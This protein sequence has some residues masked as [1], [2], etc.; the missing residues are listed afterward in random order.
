MKSLLTQEELFNKISFTHI[1]IDSCIWLE[2]YAYTESFEP[3]IKYLQ[4]VQCKILTLPIIKFEVLRSQNLENYQ[5]LDTIIDD[6]TFNF[7]AYKDKAIT[8]EALN[9]AR[10]YK[11]NNHTST[12]FTDC[13]MIS[14]IS[15]LTKS[16]F[17]LTENHKD[18]T[19]LLFDPI[20]IHPVPVQSK[21]GAL[22]IYTPCIY[23]FNRT[24]YKTELA[25]LSR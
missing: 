22:K 14:I 4:A 16:P 23:E 24:K 19:S 13:H 21:N 15:S 17:I 1:L 25:K 10:I 7:T 11:G 18:F 5:R 12:S 3:L 8:E 2:Y 6:Y 9:I 20:Y